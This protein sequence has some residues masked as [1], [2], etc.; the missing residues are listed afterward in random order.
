VTL[1]AFSDYLPAS[2][3]LKIVVVCL[4]VAVVAPASVSIAISG[5]DRRG[6]AVQ[7]HSSRAAGTLLIVGGVSVLVALITFG[8]YALVN[9]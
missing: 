1:A 6:R 2:D 5:L 4:A 9:R 7:E 3:L 8:I